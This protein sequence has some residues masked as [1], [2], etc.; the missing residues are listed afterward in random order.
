MDPI[1]SW[2]RPSEEAM[3]AF[4][5]IQA[6]AFG[7]PLR[8][9]QRWVE[10]VGAERLRLVYRRGQLVGGLGWYGA[11]QFFGGRSVPMAALAGVAIR[12]EDRRQGLARAMLTRFLRGCREQGLPISSL[13]AATHALYR[14]VG[15]EQAGSRWLA[16]VEAH[17]IGLNECGGVRAIQP[18]DQQAV[19]AAYRRYARQQQGLLDRDEILW[20]RA[21]HHWEQGALHGYLCE[22]QQGAVE[23]YLY[24]RTKPSG[25]SEGF[26]LEVSELVAN[27]PQAGRLLWSFLAQHA[28]TA[29]RILLP[30]AP[31]E[32]SFMLL[33]DLVRQ[34]ALHDNWLLR[35][36]DPVAALEARGWPAAVSGRVDLALRDK[37][38]P[39]CSGRYRLEVDAGR[40]RVTVGGAGRIEL[41]PR[42]LAALYSGFLSPRAARIAGLV[43]GESKDLDSLAS[44]LA[45]SAPWMLE[46]F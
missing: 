41:G 13:Y 29:H 28:S 35:I 26:D 15:W 39:E 19:R 34:L 18:A 8:R 16:E 6:Q 44:L 14:A 38:L 3:G 45:G 11:G 33:P 20:Q 27:G 31:A 17:R 32:P 12:P 9:A 46:G 23:G 21:T 7:E 24:Y 43:G 36:V 4:A 37:I 30:S 10:Q 42:G 25:R 40:A 2:T 22:G 5:R 1:D